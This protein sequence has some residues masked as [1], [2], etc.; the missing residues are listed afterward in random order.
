MKQD[1]STE[2]VG[3][4]QLARECGRIREKLSPGRIRLDWSETRHFELE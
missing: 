2:S 1:E 4:T 3:T